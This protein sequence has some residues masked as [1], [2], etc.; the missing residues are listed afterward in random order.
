MEQKARAEVAGPYR[1]L[2][3]IL[4][5]R[6]LTI[7]VGWL[8]HPESGAK[9]AKNKTE[10]WER[11]KHLS[12]VAASQ[13]RDVMLPS[14]PER[15]DTESDIGA[16]DMWFASLIVS[17]EAGKCEVLVFPTVFTVDVMWDR[18]S[19]RVYCPSLMRVLKR[20]GPWRD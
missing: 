20:T 5:G 12:G 11:K 3:R 9:L 18:C 8:I 7:S 14:L 19:F 10:M 17:S 4:N 1:G 15:V 16:G 6:N 2:Q 13:V